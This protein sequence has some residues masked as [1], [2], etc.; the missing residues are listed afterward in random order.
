[1]TQSE[2]VPNEDGSHKDKNEE[3]II[4]EEHETKQN[5]K[6]SVDFRQVQPYDGHQGRHVNRGNIF[7]HSSNMY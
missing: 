1:M 5:E 3:Q 6:G 4:I 2:K 7:N